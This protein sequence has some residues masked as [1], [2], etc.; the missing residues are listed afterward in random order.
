MYEK[1]T[2]SDSDNFH[3]INFL[4]VVLTSESPFPSDLRCTHQHWPQLEHCAPA[5]VS[6]APGLRGAALLR[7]PW[8]QVDVQGLSCY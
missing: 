5:G 2:K 8:V 1:Q 7:S 4:K 6:G 3:K